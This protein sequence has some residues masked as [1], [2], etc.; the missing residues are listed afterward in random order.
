MA[1]VSLPSFVK[2]LRAFNAR[3]YDTQHAFYADDIT[4][5]LPYVEPLVGKDAI[6]AQYAQIHPIA[7]EA[8]IPMD[9]VYNGR[10]FIVPKRTIFRLRQDVPELMGLKDL[11]RGDVIVY[12]AYLQ[13]YFNKEGKIRQ[14]DLTTLSDERQLGP[15]LLLRGTDFVEVVDGYQKAAAEDFGVW[16]T[17]AMKGT[18]WLD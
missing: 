18:A 8:V 6:T 10:T 15:R 11:K 7:D 2:Y 3:D 9:I 16:D 13:Y 4:L 17:A 12:T 5:N 14:I 1:A